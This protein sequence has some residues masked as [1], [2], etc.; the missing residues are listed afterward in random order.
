MQVELRLWFPQGYSCKMN[1]IHL[2][3]GFGP[4]LLSTYFLQ[5]IQKKCSKI[6]T[7]WRT[8]KMNK[9][10]AEGYWSKTMIL[11]PS[12]N[13]SKDGLFQWR[14]SNDSIC[15]TETDHFAKLCC[16]EIQALVYI[17]KNNA[18]PFLCEYSFDVVISKC[19]V[20]NRSIF[21]SPVLS[22][23]H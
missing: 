19:E 2:W 7:S 3:M 10:K 12:F 4:L 8:C 9:L 15:L 16:F 11:I 13:I 18:F 22:R 17:E 6:L 1:N 21:H 5:R 14:P 23:K 20:M